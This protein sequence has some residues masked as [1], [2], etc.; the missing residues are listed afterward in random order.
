MLK[1]LDLHGVANVERFLVAYKL[2]VV[3]FLPVLS[4]CCVLEQHSVDVMS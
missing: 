2:V 1:V 4:H 3:L